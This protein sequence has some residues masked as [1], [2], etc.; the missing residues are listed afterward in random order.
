MSEPSSP[1]ERPP[2]DEANAH[3]AASAHDA[4]VA[5]HGASE[6]EAELR[7]LIGAMPDVILVLDGEGRYR[8]V[9]ETG[10]S[11][12]YRPPHELLGR[13]LHDVFPR[14]RAD[15]FLGYIRRALE[16]G[17]P[18]EV[19]YALPI[20]GR[21]MWFDAS[22]APAGEDSVVWVARD[23]TRRKR[24]EEA[25]R[26]QALVFETIHDGVIVMDLEGRVVDWNPAAERIFGWTRAEM[27]GR[28]VGDL[29]PPELGG[30]VEAEIN[31]TVRAE[32]R[33][34]GE[35]RLVRKD[36][37]ERL[38]DVV[39]VVQRDGSGEP[40]GIIG[41]NRDVTER[42]TVDEALRRSEEQLRQAQKIEAV[43]RLAGGIAHD[44]NNLLTAISSS[45]EL[46]L[47]ALP[48]D[49]PA[50]DDLR[51]I[52]QAAH[53]AAAL[54][55][56]LLAFSRNQVLQPRVLDLN[57]VVGDA[58][59]MLRR[60]LP[61]DVALLTALDPALGYVRADPGQIEQ[62]LVNLVVNARDAMP[63]GG[64]IV[65]ETANVAVDDAML[66]AHPE[67]SPGEH[68]VLRVRD[69]GHGMDDE[70]LAR[71]FEPF[72]TTKESGHGTGLG[73][74][75]VYGIVRQ[76]GG[77]VVV[78]SA[79]GVGT[80]FHIILPRVE[81]HPR[82]EGEAA[83]CSLPRGSETVLLVEDEPSVRVAARRILEMHGYRVVEAEHGL[84]A[85]RRREELGGGVDLL[86]T[87]VVMPEM[88]GFELASRLRARQ[89]GLPVL[90]MS[91]YPDGAGSAAPSGA[92]FIAKPFAAEALVRQ[93][94]ELLDTAGARRAAARD[95]GAARS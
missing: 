50:R 29:H 3:E 56:Q 34:Q 21:S 15:A 85:L 19:E 14:E 77:H 45:A 60:I 91:G 40:V 57:L 12:L 90:L 31:H 67:L 13:R 36:G 71:I 63:G 9:L 17:E 80:A 10:V 30:R 28:S 70:T 16:T 64:A 53:R 84:D 46:A 74:A 51:E 81:E 47:A 4:A 43:G 68:V 7:A 78:E 73:L 88:G 18:V 65:V 59:R 25:L 8:K 49:T 75:T 24:A 44:F 66:S 94:R 83:H 54:T 58:E 48:A 76:S 20:G 93:V 79:P 27:L 39:V 26:R 89:P 55:R 37:A 35:L 95:P 87:D 92:G 82:A 69:T 23:I 38:V 11:S 22:I 1:A 33:W 2:H 61:A 52:Q 62:V 72:F 42:R 6:S 32:G 86:L 5:A 41:V